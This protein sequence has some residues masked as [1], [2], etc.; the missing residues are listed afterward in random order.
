MSDVIVMCPTVQRASY[1][2]EK[3]CKV[4]EEII[5]KSRR[6]PY[7]VTL[8]NGRTFIF[9]GETEGVR[10]YRG[11]HADVINIDDFVIEDK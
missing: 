9:R 5:A 10:A 11:Y 3:F 2:F 8:L 4:Y 6:N 7:S 1:E